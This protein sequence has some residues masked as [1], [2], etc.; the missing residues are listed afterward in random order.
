MIILNLKDGLG[1]QMFEY[2]FAKR[3]QR[4]YGEEIVFNNFFFEGG[5]R[6]KYSLYHF[7]LSEKIKV[8]NRQQQILNTG[9]FMAK[10][11]LCYPKTFIEWMISNK[12]PKDE[13]IFKRSSKKGLYVQFNTFHKFDIVQSKKKNKYIYGNFENYC[14]IEDIIEDLRKDFEIISEPSSE[15]KKMIEILEKDNTVC[16]HIRRGDYM[17]PTWKMMQVCDFDYYQRAINIVTSKVPD[18]KFYVFSNNHEDLKWI[19]ENYHFNVPLEYVDLGNPDYEELRLMMKCNH[20]IIS[21]STFSWWAAVLAN[22]S[23]K[24]V[25]APK[26]WINNISDDDTS[27]EDS[28][29]MYLKNWIRI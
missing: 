24:V 7:K 9:I 6:R 29:G 2:G 21:N 12:R 14:Y 25:V 16:L 1:N 4:L 11:F 26:K 10:L 17:D 5:K 19:K 13:A 15:N 28:A 20:F 18:A 3:L 8:L 22:K 23:N 27:E